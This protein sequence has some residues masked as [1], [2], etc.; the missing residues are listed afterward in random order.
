MF[1]A[2]YFAHVNI[3]ATNAKNAVHFYQ[4]VFGFSI[5]GESEPTV[6]QDGAMFNLEGNVNW[7]GVFLGDGRGLKGPILD[8]LEWIEPP[9]AAPSGELTA[10]LRAVIIGTDDLAAVAAKLKLHGRPTQ[11]C[12]IASS[13]QPI[14]SIIS[15]DLDGTRLEIHENNLG[16]RFQGLRLVCQDLQKSIGFYAEALHFEHDDVSVYQVLAETRS[17]EAGKSCK[18]YLP[19]QSP[20]FFL[21]L[22]KLENVKL[23][24]ARSLRG[25]VRGTYRMALLVD[26]VSEAYDDLV[27]HIPDL[28]PPYHPNIGD[29][30]DPVPAI[31]FN[32]P[33][34]TVVEY[35]VGALA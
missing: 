19:G 5:L 30:Y 11:A 17:I 22:T 35:L 23:A 27:Q 14:R 28:S 20:K 34:G 4:D 2:R 24:D 10:G 7:R 1:R 16:L 18:A 25:N 9:T 32:D 3:N 31:F 33:D 6:Q 15:S 26:D 29:Q 13:N 8:L 12:T 21:E